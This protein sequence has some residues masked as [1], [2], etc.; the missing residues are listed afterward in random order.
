MPIAITKERSGRVV[1]GIKTQ[2]KEI[3]KKN[4]KG[5]I[6]ITSVFLAGVVLSF[7]LNISAS[8]E[9]EIKLYIND[10]ISNVKSY[11]VDS[12]K[13]FRLSMYGYIKTITL[14]LTMSLCI[15][16]NYGILIYTFIKGFSYGA[17]FCALMNT[18][19]VKTSLIFMSIAL[20]HTVISLPCIMTYLLFCFKNSCVIFN[21][22]NGLKNRIFIS[23]AFALLS[24]GVLCISAL[25]Q[26]YLEPLLIRMSTL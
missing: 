8:Y 26:A 10:F 16:G 12:V 25:I 2:I 3:L 20:L 13:T 9:E 17:V 23:L 11:S 14:L 24:I 1:E 18:L 5:Y 21:G 19:E 4:S 22:E 15:V 6:L 7:L